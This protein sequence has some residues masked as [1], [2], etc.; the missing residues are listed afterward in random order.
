ML[1]LPLDKA[2]TKTALLVGTATGVFVTSAEK[3]SAAASW[4]RLGACSDLPLVLVAGLS[5]EPL[6]DTLVAATMG[7]G[8]YIV[9]KA[10]D[11]LA[12]TLR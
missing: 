9:H 4:Q 8:V 7:R 3:G 6:D 5:H 10:T 12:A 1:L 11:V 2:G